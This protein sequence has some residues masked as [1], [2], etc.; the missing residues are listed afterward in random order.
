MRRFLPTD[1]PNLF[2]PDWSRGAACTAAAVLLSGCAT[3]PDAAS[4]AALPMPETLAASR[5]FAAPAADWPAD[6]WWRA[7]ADPQLDALMG[8]AEYQDYVKSL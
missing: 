6:A 2:L 5:S 8:E 3:I 7:Y 4:H 1:H